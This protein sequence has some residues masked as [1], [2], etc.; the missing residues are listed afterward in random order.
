RI[1]STRECRNEIAFNCHSD[2]PL[3]D[4][5]FICIARPPQNMQVF[6]IGTPRKKVSYQAQAMDGTDAR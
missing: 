5:V 6:F 1:R 3:W 2:H 4:Y